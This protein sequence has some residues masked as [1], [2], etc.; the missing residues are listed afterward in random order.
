MPRQ[1]GSRLSEGTATGKGAADPR[2]NLET[3]HA[4]GTIRP[5]NG[6]SDM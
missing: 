1:A 4:L 2:G 5:V 3:A 6:F